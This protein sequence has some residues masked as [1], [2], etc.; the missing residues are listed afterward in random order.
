M[1][2]PQGASDKALRFLLKKGLQDAL[3]PVFQRMSEMTAGIEGD[4]Q[5]I[6]QGLLQEAESVIAEIMEEQKARPQLR[7]KLH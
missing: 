3:N 1:S 7:A 2:L 4:K 6:K 5:Q